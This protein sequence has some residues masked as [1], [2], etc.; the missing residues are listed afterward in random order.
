MKKLFALFLFLAVCL[1]AADFWQSKPFTEWSDKDVLKM[2]TD[3]PWAHR[4]SV[5]MGTAAPSASLPSSGRRGTGGDP[6]GLEDAIPNGGSSAGAANRPGVGD[7]NSGGYGG[8]GDNGNRAGRPGD[9]PMGGMGGQGMTLVVR[10]YTA[11]PMK[12]AVMRSKYGMEVKTS[13]EAK[14]FLEREEPN[15]VIAVAGL[16]AVIGQGDQDKLKKA[17]MA[18]TSLAGKTSSGLKPS[19]IQFSPNDKSVDAFFIFPKT[20]VFT[21]DDKDVEF[22]TRVGVLAVKYKFHL[23]DMV[24]GGKLEL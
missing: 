20:A 14:K 15:Y 10:W 16:P 3:S 6:T 18:Q 9:E 21:L 12:Q 19:D 5:S 13:P 8:V 1:W 2:V 11:L 17:T 23:K 7:T 24:F 4:I 22:S